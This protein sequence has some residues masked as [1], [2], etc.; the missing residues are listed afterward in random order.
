[1]LACCSVRGHRADVLAP[2][3]AYDLIDGTIMILS[4]STA[5]FHY[6]W[7]PATPPVRN[8]PSRINRLIKFETHLH[9]FKF[10]SYWSRVFLFL[11]KITSGESQLRNF[12]VGKYI[13]LNLT[14]FI[15]DLCVCLCVCAYIDTKAWIYV[16]LIWCLIVDACLWVSEYMWVHKHICD[17]MYMCSYA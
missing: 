1:M 17:S 6:K 10:L 7:I 13:F 15:I 2:D 11:S 4:Y 8:Q 12:Q 14:N 16:Y 9:R 5:N 3:L